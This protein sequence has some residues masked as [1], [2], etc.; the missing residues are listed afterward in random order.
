MKSR[1]RNSPRH[2]GTEFFLDLIIALPR[3]RPIGG[4]SRSSNPWD[5][6]GTIQQS[7][8]IFAI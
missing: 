5:T 6:R 7:Y 1:L 8:Q 3:G 2:G 4:G